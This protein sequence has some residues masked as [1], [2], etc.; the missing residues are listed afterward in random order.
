MKNILVTGG[1][2]FIGSNFVRHLLE[3]EPDVRVI[4]LD[5]LTYAGSLEN[6]K[7]LPGADRHAFVQGDICNRDLVS[8]L[9]RKHQIDT[10]VHFAAE[11]HVDRS[12]L[13]PEPFIQTNVFGTFAL[14]E[15]ARQY[16]LVEKAL[17]V[18]QV[19]FHHVS[20]DEVYGTLKPDDPAFSETTP[21]APNSPYAASKASSDHLVRSYHHTYQMPVTISNCSNN[22]GPRQFPEKLIPLV[23]LNALT[24]K[25]LPVYGDGQ[26]IRDWLY[27]TD[28]CEAIHRILAKGQPGETYNIGGNNQP[29]NLTIVETICDLLDELKPASEPR[30]KLIQF[31][32]DR[33]GHDRRYAMNIA[34]IERELGWKPRYSLNE[35]LLATVQWILSNPE[36][37]EAIQKQKEYQSWVDKNYEKR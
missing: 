25:P 9:L 21:Y 16:W 30:R 8:E 2:G 14:L 32:T 12:I 15:A 23:I 29:A 34:R 27:V 7:D 33:P 35:G 26:Q 3:V 31:V 4:N 11:S 13:G 18:G 28:H 10:I 5:A 24:G 17:P 6:L 20:T 22:Y 1:A 37:L 36:W 19:R